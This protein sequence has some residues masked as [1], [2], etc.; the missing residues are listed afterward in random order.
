ML[1]NINSINKEIERL[2]KVV[3]ELKTPVQSKILPGSIIKAAKDLERYLLEVDGLL[4]CDDVV[5][6][7]DT[8]IVILDPS[9]PPE[10]M[11]GKKLRNKKDLVGTKEDILLN[12]GVILKA[13]VIKKQN[14]CNMAENDMPIR[15]IFLILL[16]LK[17]V[18]IK[19]NPRKDILRE[20][21][22]FNPLLKT[23][24]YGSTWI[25]MLDDYLCVSLFHKT[26]NETGFYE[27]M[28]EFI[29]YLEGNSDRN[30]TSLW[31]LVLVNDQVLLNQYMDI[32]AFK[33]EYDLI[34]TE[35]GN[36]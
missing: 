28:G 35:V 17:D 14:L 25:E 15:G 32:R 13:G 8:T 5:M 21:G 23:W 2:G 11:S 27:S 33:Y 1:F 19:Q 34:K 30:C 20:Y 36:E 24:L 9:N 3:P 31:S 10:T 16:T 26:L 12:N 29:E 7:K 6:V 18:L 22:W 4:Y